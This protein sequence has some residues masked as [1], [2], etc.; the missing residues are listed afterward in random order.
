[1]ARHRSEK[2]A[3]SRRMEAFFIRRIIWICA[4]HG[5]SY[6]PQLVHHQGGCRKLIAATSLEIAIGSVAVFAFRFSYQFVVSLSHLLM[7]IVLT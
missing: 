1:M 6:G 5:I 3:A 2:S 4:V 7:S